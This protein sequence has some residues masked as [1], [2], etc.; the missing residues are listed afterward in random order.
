MNPY[1]EFFLYQDKDEL[2]C[3]QKLYATQN[4]FNNKFKVILKY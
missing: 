2:L 4:A 1:L 3:E